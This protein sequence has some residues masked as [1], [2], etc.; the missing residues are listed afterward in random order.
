[1]NG[2]VYLFLAALGLRYCVGFSLAPTTG[3]PL[4]V[5]RGLLTALASL[6]VKHRLLARGLP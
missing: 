1:M 2:F 6:A 4:T 5:V 3:A